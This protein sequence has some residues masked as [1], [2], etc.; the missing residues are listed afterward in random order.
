MFTT[1]KLYC[2]GRPGAGTRK[3]IAVA[4]SLP[5]I[6]KRPAPGKSVRLQIIPTEVLLRAGD[7]QTF[8]IRSIDANGLP[9]SWID[10]KEAVFE[11]WIPATAK[12]RVKL[13][14]TVD[15]AG[16]LTADKVNRS[17]AGAFR[18]T[19]GGLVGTFRGRT[20]PALPMHEDFESFNVSVPHKTEQSVTFAY[21]PLAW[22]GARFKWEIRHEDAGAGGDAGAGAGNSVFTKTIDRLLFQRALTYIGHPD[23]TNYTTAAAA[24]ASARAD[25]LV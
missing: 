15:D 2:F 4:V 17:S 6:A 8:R 19:H 5:A 3:T 25:R 11:K 10:P 13:S 24:T 20:M 16:R 1:K 22:I 12:V 9:V 14:A 18:V 21:P 7:T 23:L